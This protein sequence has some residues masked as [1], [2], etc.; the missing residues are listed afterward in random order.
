MMN[1]DIVGNFLGAKQGQNVLNVI[2]HVLALDS[3]PRKIPE[4]RATNQA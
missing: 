2:T 3:L 4:T 1:M